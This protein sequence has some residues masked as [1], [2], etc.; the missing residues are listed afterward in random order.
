MCVC[1]FR[2]ELREGLL[3]LEVGCKKVCVLEVRC[4]NGVCQRRECV[5]GCGVGARPVYL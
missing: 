3:F 4:N 5:F 2:G 1:V